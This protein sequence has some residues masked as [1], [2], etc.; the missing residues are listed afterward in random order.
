MGYE[1]M[2]HCAN[3]RE[4]ADVYQPGFWLCEG[5]TEAEIEDSEQAE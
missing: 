5:C 3:C 2:T 4:P 1:P